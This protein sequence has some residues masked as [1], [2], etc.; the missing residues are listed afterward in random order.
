MARVEKGRQGTLRALII[1]PSALGDTLLLAPALH[2]IGKRA[3]LT[4][5]GRRPGIDF[6]KPL[7]TRCID[8]ETGG[9]HALFLDEPNCEELHLPEVDRVI[10]FLSNPSSTAK[11]GL[12]FLMKQTPIFTFPPFPPEGETIHVALYLASCLKNSGLP[13]DPDAALEEAQTN[14]LLRREESSRPES[15]IVFHPGSGSTKKNL[16]PEFWIDLMKTSEFALFEKRVLL[17]GPAEEERYHVF[18]NKLRGLDIEIVTSPPSEALLSLLKAASLYLGHDSGV[19]H[20]AALLGLSTIALFKNSD[21]LQ[22]APLG[23]DVTVISN[24][25]SPEQIYGIIKEKAIRVTG[26]LS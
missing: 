18:S 24:F 20:L 3:E 15:M 13:V 14:G 4:L 7:A 6:L 21:P 26:I 10:S 23:P 25:E 5:V 22:W 17:L 1:R 11:R 2:N 12:E 9:W 16:A 8:Y 19:T